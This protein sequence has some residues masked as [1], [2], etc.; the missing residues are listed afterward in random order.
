MLP[1]R[2][3]LLA[4]GQCTGQRPRP[5]RR[6]TA[7]WRDLDTNAHFEDR[8][9]DRA[10]WHADAGPSYLASDA[11]SPPAAEIGVADAAAEVRPCLIN[12]EGEEGAYGRCVVS[13]TCFFLQGQALQPVFITWRTCMFR[14]QSGGRVRGHRRRLGRGCQGVSLFCSASPACDSPEPPSW[15]AS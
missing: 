9:R 11:A 6:G 10:C 1:E 13:Y 2:P 14:R 15:R 8:D 7:G 3:E 5:R 4:A 12:R